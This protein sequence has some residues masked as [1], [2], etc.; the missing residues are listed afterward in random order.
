MSVIGFLQSE[1]IA[2]ENQGNVSFTIGLIS[3][4]LRID[5]LFNFSTADIVSPTNRAEGE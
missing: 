1:Y 5:A 2:V 4:Q 3:G